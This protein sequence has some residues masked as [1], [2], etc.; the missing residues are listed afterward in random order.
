MSPALRR[1]L[2]VQLSTYEVKETKYPGK[3]QWVLESMFASIYNIKRRFFLSLILENEKLD[4][5]V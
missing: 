2:D 5:E 3:L 4:K 1:K